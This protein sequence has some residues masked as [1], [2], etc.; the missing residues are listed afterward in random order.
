MTML[1]RCIR[2]ENS[3]LRRSPIWL[4]FLT[5]PAISAVY[6]TFNFNIL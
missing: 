2:A 4:L 3:K 6:G 1:L 5:V